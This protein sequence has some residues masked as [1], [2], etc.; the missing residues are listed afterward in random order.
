MKVDK[1]L[2]E[3][4]RACLAV[5]EEGR[6]VYRNL[7]EKT[8]DADIK[9]L[10][11]NM[12]NDEE[13]HISYWKELLDLAKRGMVPQVFDNPLR[14]G[15][16]V[17]S[18]QSKIAELSQQ[19]LQVEDPLRAFLLACRLEF[20]ILDPAFS[21]L[22]HYLGDINSQISPE[23]QYKA[24]LNRL[25]DF[26]KS[27]PSSTP[28]IELLSESIVSLWQRNRELVIQS[29]TDTLT[30]VHNRRGFFNI[31]TPLCYLAQRN[32]YVVAIMMIDIDDFKKVNDKHGH[33]IG[34]AVLTFVA[35][36]IKDQIRR[37][38]VVGRYGGEEFVVCLIDA[39][40]DSLADI[41]ERMRQTI[42]NRSQD[43]IPISVS[44]GV[45][46]GSLEGDVE[47]RLDAMI[48]LADES[49]YEAKELGKNQVVLRTG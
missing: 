3:I 6:V 30:G 28:E 40:S 26:V 25:I 1:E 27:H 4:I 35:H 47:E 42:Q 2:V 43:R 14:V 16:T 13:E 39:D 36:T 24:H 34:D 7:A 10:W 17:T 5:E 12:A 18:L 19:S 41:S 37:S 8:S 29:Q 9:T 20:W 21:T 15:E 32:D 45:N 38:D 49:L 46:Y 22:F 44:I 31:I 33:Q 23:T 48:R 11:D